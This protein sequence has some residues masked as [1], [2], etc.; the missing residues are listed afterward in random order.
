MHHKVIYGALETTVTAPI[1]TPA[2][3]KDIQAQVSKVVQASVI[4][5]KAHTEQFMKNVI[6]KRLADPSTEAQTRECLN[7][8]KENYSDAN[9]DISRVMEDLSSGDYYKAMVD[10]E[11]ISTFVDTCYDCLHEMVGDEPE[12]KKFDDWVKGVTGDCLEQ[13]DKI[14]S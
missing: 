1:D 10:V 2:V 3:G 5:V 7:Q 13:L 14:N 12:F 8:C 6:A 11:G 9:D 4:A